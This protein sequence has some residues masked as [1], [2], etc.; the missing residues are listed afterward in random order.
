[1]Q[2]ISLSRDGECFVLPDRTN[3]N[4]MRWRYATRG[5]NCVPVDVIRIRRD[6]SH[7]QQSITMI[8]IL[9]SERS[10]CIRSNHK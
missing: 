3:F 2:N 8:K 4:I 1:M 6:F 7:F 9:G 5:K 10:R